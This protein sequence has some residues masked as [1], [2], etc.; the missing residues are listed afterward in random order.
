MSANLNDESAGSGDSSCSGLMAFARGQSRKCRGPL[1]YLTSGSDVMVWF[2]HSWVAVTWFVLGDIRAIGGRWQ[3]S[4][5]INIA[6][7][8]FHETLPPTV[9]Q[10][11]ILIR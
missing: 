8:G 10:H 11:V 4:A 7:R 5:V 2:R 6:L 9:P 1:G 3:T